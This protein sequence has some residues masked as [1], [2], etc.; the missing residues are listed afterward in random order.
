MMS[1]SGF[2]ARPGTDVDPTC[3]T[4]TAFEPSAARIRVASRWNSRG[5]SG[6]YSASSIVALCSVRS[7]TVAARISSSVSATPGRYPGGTFDHEVC[8]KLRFEEHEVG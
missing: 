4:C 3:S 1:I 5:H 6:S 7:P 2:A 8:A